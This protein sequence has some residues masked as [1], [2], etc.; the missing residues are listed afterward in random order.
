MTQQ[1]KVIIS[2][3]TLSGAPLETVRAEVGRAFRLEGAQLA[4]MLSGKAVIVSRQA[5]AEK[6]EQLLAK[7]QALDLEARLEPLA[8]VA[9]PVPVAPEP[10]VA[11]APK[12]VVSDE[13]FDLPP[14]VATPTPVAKPPVP[15][16]SASVAP[17]PTM[18]SGEPAI[19]PDA[20][21]LCPKCGE[22]QP[23]RT[24]CRRC[25]TD[26]PRYLAAQAQAE[27]EARDARAAEIMERRAAPGPLRKDGSEWQAGVLGL[28]FSGRLGCLDYLAGTLLSS[29]VWLL[30][31]LLAMLSGKMA[32]SWLGIF[33]SSIY[34]LRCL[35]LRLHDTG[36]TGWLS[37][38]AL[39]PFLGLVMMIILLFIWGDD[40]ENEHGMPA[41]RSGGL[42]AIASL[43][44]V[45]VAFGLSFRNI[46]QSP[47]KA[48][49]FLEA[50][51]AGQSKALA[52]AAGEADDDAGDD[53]PDAVAGPQASV[54]YASNNR[55]D[56]YL[57]AECTDCTRM[58][59]WLDANRL[60]YTVYAV[61]SNEQA[62]ER[63]HS[64]VAGN[65]GGGGTIQLPVLEINGKVLPGNPD[66]GSV[67]RQL[68]QEG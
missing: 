2:G 47:E 14:P 35:A 21:M 12:T 59:A 34:Y 29:L 33:L 17:A 15:A 52:A 46:G 26:M 54:R 5:P 66:V 1:F 7:L 49:K 23:R 48:L 10:V 30:F 6:A 36:R 25:G 37:L 9:V 19:A 65:G 53:E 3:R 41:A 51:S 43:L 58:R 56:I 22:G 44:V 8:E 31:V 45:S 28:G 60:R 39:V 62:A 50:A 4:Q 55:I 11:L 63:L 32:F 40:G 27:S 38:V 18:A 61:D 16:V 13:L 20:E 64:I 42:R 24:L 68:R 67:H 57:T